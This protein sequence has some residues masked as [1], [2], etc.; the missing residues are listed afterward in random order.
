VTMPMPLLIVLKVNVMFDTFPVHYEELKNDE[1]YQTLSEAYHLG[2]FR[3]ISVHKSYALLQYYL[4]C[5]HI[6]SK[7]SHRIHPNFP[8]LHS[9]LNKK[10]YPNT[11]SLFQLNVQIVWFY[12]LET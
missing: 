1:I 10:T 9:I 4:L 11:T 12:L 8:E 5:F 6:P 2:F 7:S 3:L